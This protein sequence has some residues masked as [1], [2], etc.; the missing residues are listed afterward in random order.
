[1]NGMDCYVIC[2][3]MTL[4]Y[5]KKSEK[6]L[7]RVLGEF[8][9]VCVRGKLRVKAGKSKVMV[10]EGKKLE[11]L[12]FSTPCRVNIPFVETKNVRL[13]GWKCCK[14]RKLKLSGNL[15]TILEQF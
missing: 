15:S 14:R 9:K 13:E 11:V 7:Q 1:M 2:L 4:S 5:S 12:S 6:E 8:Y 3:R 10:F